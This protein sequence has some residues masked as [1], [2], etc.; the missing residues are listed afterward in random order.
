[1]KATE[2]KASKKRISRKKDGGDGSAK[3]SFSAR[4]RRLKEQESKSWEA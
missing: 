4:A 3:T 2:S 1:M